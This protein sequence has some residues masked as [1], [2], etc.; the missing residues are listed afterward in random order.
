MK[1]SDPRNPFALFSLLVSMTL[2]GLLHGQTPISFD[3]RN[4]QDQVTSSTITQS[5]VSLTVASQDRW[6]STLFGRPE[7]LAVFADGLS[8][9][10]PQTIYPT[11]TMT[12]SEDVTITSFTLTNTIYSGG[13][14]DSGNQISLFDGVTTQIIDVNNDRS[15]GEVITLA[16]PINLAANQALSLRAITPL[17]SNINN[18]RFSHL[19]VTAVP[20]PSIYALLVGSIVL[21]GVAIRR[22]HRK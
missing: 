3:L 10:Y 11:M 9:L 13:Y 21:I 15:Y 4:L 8:V 12:F 6:Y 22:K 18:V 14:G 16:T 5:G 2:S 20:E 17:G 1:I 19:H 7:G